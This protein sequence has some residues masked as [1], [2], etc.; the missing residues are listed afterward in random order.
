[1]FTI[2][3]YINMNRSEQK[4]I[5]GRDF[6]LVSVGYIKKKGKLLFSRYCS[7]QQMIEYFFNSV[8]VHEREKHIFSV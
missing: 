8:L 6:S 4:K 1:M 3:A 2:V 7:A 5:L